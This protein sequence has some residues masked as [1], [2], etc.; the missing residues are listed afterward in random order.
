M[1]RVPGRA[2]SNE[3]SHR[4]SN[5]RELAVLIPQFQTFARKAV[6][7]HDCV[8]TQRLQV[9]FSYVVVEFN[10]GETP[11]RQR[12]ALVPV[13]SSIDAKDQRADRLG[14]DPAEAS[15]SDAE[16]CEEASKFHGIADCMNGARDA[17]S[18]LSDISH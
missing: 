9:V 3:L 7:K 14:D 4:G 2:T 6:E 15:R 1:L 5:Q 16:F 11:L 18:A 10:N 12:P 13:E 17:L 8:R